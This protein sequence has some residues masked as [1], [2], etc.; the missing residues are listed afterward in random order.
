MRQKAIKSFAVMVLFGLIE[1]APLVAQENEVPAGEA[2]AEKSFAQ[3]IVEGYSHE[4]KGDMQAAL[5]SYTQAIG[6]NDKSP[7]PYMR[8]AYVSAKL[9]KTK[10]AARDLKKAIELPPK[11]KTDFTTMAWFYSTSPFKFYIDAPRAITLATKVHSEHPSAETHDILAAAYAAMGDYYKARTLLV[12]G[13]KLF[14]DAER[15]TSMKSRLDLY[16]LEKRYI[17]AWGDM[18]M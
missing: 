1:V 17:E 2:V 3:W 13:M 5:E 11:S 9:G 8:R 4:S 10:D 12:Q 6:L 15:K 14:P 18:K 16:K 7:T